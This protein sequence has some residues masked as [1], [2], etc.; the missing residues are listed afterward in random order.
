MDI[1]VAPPSFSLH[2]NRI[3]SLSGWVGGEEDPKISNS[4]WM[5]RGKVASILVYSRK[6][7]PEQIQWRRG[8]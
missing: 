2:E 3:P 6:V 4:E 8:L 1:L 7:P 5:E